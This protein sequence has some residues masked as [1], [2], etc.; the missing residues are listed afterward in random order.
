MSLVCLLLLLAANLAAQGATA[1]P[2]S[3]VHAFPSNGTAATATAATATVSVSGSGPAQLAAATQSGGNW[4]SVTPST[5]TLPLTPTVTMDPSGLPDGTYL[6]AITIGS[7]SVPVTITVGNPGPRLPAN[8]IVNAASYQG[9]AI[10]PGEIVALFG[11][12]IGP[13]VPYGTQVWDGV[14]TTRLAATRV[15]FGTTLA[16][17]IYAYANQVAAVVPYSVAGTTTVQVQVENLVARTPPIS[18]A[19]QVATPGLFTADASG[20]GQLAALNQDTSPN[21]PSNPAAL[22]SIIVL[23][24]TGAGVMNP[25]VADGT[26]VTSTQLPA[27]VLPTQVSIGGQNAQVL[28]AGAA[29]TLIAGVIQ[30]NARIPASIATGNVPVVWTIG[31]TTSPSG[32]TVSVH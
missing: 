23:F 24:A 7:A 20:K 18:V 19:V 22:G 16:P 32:C 15:W 26:L 30:I 2:A 11:T 28:Y 29:P 12:S 10:S 31:N 25:A 4:L 21:S 8:G 9:N 3:I 14:V 5:G 27:P 6:G 13:Q 1:N 17:L